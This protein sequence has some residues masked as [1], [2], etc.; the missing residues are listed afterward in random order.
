[1]QNKVKDILSRNLPTEGSVGVAVSGGSD[2]MCLLDC[3]TRYDLIEKSRITVINAEHGIRGKES[4]R[5]SFFVK[6]YCEKHGLRLVQ[7]SADIPKLA[8]QSDRSIETEARIFRKRIFERL[9][10]E[11]QVS[12][13]LLAHNLNDRT[14]TVLMHIFRGSGLKGLVGMT[15]H[16]G[17]IIRPLIDCDKTEILKYVRENNV[18]F[19]EDSTN[20]DDTYS[21]NFLRLKVLPLI[22]ARYE[23]LDRAV[24]N[25]SDIAALSSNAEGVKYEDESALIKTD[26]LTGSAVIA[27]FE[28][29]GLTVDYTKKHIDAVVALKDK[30]TGAGVDLPHGYRAEKE[31]GV[32]RIFQKTDSQE[33]DVPLQKGETVIGERVVTVTETSPRADK[34]DTV[35]ALDKLPKNAVIRTRR[36]GDVF[37]PYGGGT[38]P[39]SDWLIDKKIPRYKRE[40]LLFVASG[41]EVFAVIGVCTGEKVKIDKDTK[42]AV[43]IC[44]KRSERE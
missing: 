43:R 8:K 35:L 34:T 26:N 17:Y 13:V 39:L 44:V 24:A 14:E 36:E 28:N 27:A 6:E 1:M 20:A 41:K 7:E 18:P 10:N 11:K 4:L 21:R 2:S 25:L 33:I 5:D 16:D 37:T 12:A 3:L 38:K 32:V 15:E 31:S 29:A 40:Q 42:N 9:I 23:G 30:S 22:R 19:V